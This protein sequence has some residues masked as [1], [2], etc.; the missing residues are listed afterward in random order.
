M[1]VHTMVG[2]DLK[3][4]GTEEPKLPEVFHNGYHQ[5]GVWSPWDGTVEDSL[6]QYAPLYDTLEAAA[7]KLN[8][9]IVAIK[10]LGRKPYPE[11][12]GYIAAKMWCKSNGDTNNG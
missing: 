4:P 6:A 10:F 11:G 8:Y 2:G 3:A 12:E 9:R 5:Y 1:P 7:K